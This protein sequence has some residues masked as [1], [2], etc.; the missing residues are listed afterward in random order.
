MWRSDYGSSGSYWDIAYTSKIWG[1]KRCFLNW[2]R[3]VLGASACSSNGQGIWNDT[4]FQE[5]VEPQNVFSKI[6]K[7]YPVKKSCESRSCWCEW[8]SCWLWGPF[9]PMILIFVKCNDLDDCDVHDRCLCSDVLWW[10]KST[11]AL[12][13][14]MDRSEISIMSSTTLTSMLGLTIWCL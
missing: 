7:F 12:V 2:I 3:K 4:C 6:L 9:W 1:G 13:T 14:V 5:K 8:C 10:L 11:I